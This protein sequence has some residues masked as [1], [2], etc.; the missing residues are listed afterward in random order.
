[1]PGLFHQ[2]GAWTQES[3]PRRIISPIATEKTPKT[4]AKTPNIV[5]M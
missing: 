3:F 2:H 1:M 5:M 4:R